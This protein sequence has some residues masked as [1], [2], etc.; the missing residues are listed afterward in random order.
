MYHYYIK[1]QNI[2]KINIP[3]QSCWMLRKICTM[4]KHLQKIGDMK[5]IIVQGKFIISKAYRKIRGE[6][7]NI[8]WTKLLCHNVVE[9][10]HNFML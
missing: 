8:H 6:V 2:F 10:K 4:G 7:D 3:Q 1:K 5:S 9:P